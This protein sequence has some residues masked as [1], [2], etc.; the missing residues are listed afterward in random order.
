MVIDMNCRRTPQ[1][2][3]TEISLREAAFVLQRTVR[4]VERMAE[5]LRTPNG[6]PGL[7]FQG[8]HR[9]V[10]VGALSAYLG[11]E[12]ADACNDVTPQS[13]LRLIVLRRADVP[14]FVSRNARPPKL[15][16]LLTYSSSGPDAVSS[17]RGLGAPHD[18]SHF[19]GLAPSVNG[20]GS[21]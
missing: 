12:D 13:V 8:G 4:S 19:N 9:V 2:P 20:Q 3:R 6:D 16:E 1:G 7:F 10:A 17:R 11:L 18:R 14:R 5:V 21:F 15:R